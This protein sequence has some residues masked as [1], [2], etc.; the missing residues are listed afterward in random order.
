[1]RLI[2]RSEKKSR[3]TNFASQFGVTVQRGMRYHIIDEESL[4]FSI[5]FS[6]YSD[7]QYDFPTINVFNMIYPPFRFSIWFSHIKANLYVYRFAL[8]YN[9]RAIIC[10]KMSSKRLI[11]Q[12]L[13]GWLGNLACGE[14]VVKSLTNMSQ[15]DL[16]DNVA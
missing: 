14:T 10:S 5:W 15:S 13:R 3:K 2:P 12:S 6:H 16:I 11:S 4:M 1:M 7:F 8:T 9:F